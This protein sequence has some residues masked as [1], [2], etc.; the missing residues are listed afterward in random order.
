MS[1]QAA[2]RGDGVVGEDVTHNALAGSLAGAPLA[3]SAKATS[4][5]AAAALPRGQLPELIEVR[6]EVYMKDEDFV[7]VN[8]KMMLFMIIETMNSDSVGARTKLPG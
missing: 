7:K 4:A 5:A 1:L 8:A 6:G 3:L 2:T